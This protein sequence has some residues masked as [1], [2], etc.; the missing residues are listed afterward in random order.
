MACYYYSSKSDFLFKAKTPTKRVRIGKTPASG[1]AVA[2][3]PRK[4]E[5]AFQ[6]CEGKAGLMEMGR[7]VESNTN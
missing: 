1:K 3:D 4:G 2:A 5:E 6:I 7:R